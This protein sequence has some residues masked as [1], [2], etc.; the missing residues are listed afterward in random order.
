MRCFRILGLNDTVILP[1]WTA[2]WSKRPYRFFTVCF[3]CVWR[4]LKLICREESQLMSY[5]L[6]Y[7]PLGCSYLKPDQLYGPLVGSANAGLVQTSFLRSWKPQI[8]CFLSSKSVSL[9]SSQ[10]I[11]FSGA[12]WLTRSCCWKW[13]WPSGLRSTS[14]SFS[15]GVQAN[16]VLHPNLFLHADKGNGKKE[17]EYG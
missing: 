10:I 4:I 8:Y 3:A 11:P 16:S 17:R 2:G 12:K 13:Q 6:L 5:F 9:A 14:P 1:L 7:H 15:T